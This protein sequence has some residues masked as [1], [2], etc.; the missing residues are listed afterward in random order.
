MPAGRPPLFD[1]NDTLELKVEEYFDY[2]KGEYHEE[3]VLVDPEKKEYQKIIVWDRYPEPPTITG[4]CFFLGFESRQSF[5]DYS[6]NEEFSYTIKRA[7]LRVEFEYEKSLNNSKN[8]TAQIFALKNLGWV[9]RQ[10]IDQVV[11]TIPLMNIDPLSDVTDGTD[12]S[13]T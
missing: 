5:H 11:R 4:L 1:S 2:I 7:R 12:N 13:A 10:E 3:E 8:P 6:K 9:D